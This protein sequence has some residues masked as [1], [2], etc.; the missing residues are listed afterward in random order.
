[1]LSTIGT[2]VAV[3]CCDNEGAMVHAKGSWSESGT[4]S[5]KVVK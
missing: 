2:D 5:S 1:M 4:I 3:Q